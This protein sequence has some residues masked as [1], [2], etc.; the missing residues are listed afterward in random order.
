MKD[1][2][3]TIG[4]SRTAT[5]EEIKK[6]Y[7]QKAKELHPDKEG[8]D[9]E[10]MKALVTAYQVLSD[11]DRRAKYDNTG[12]I[13]EDNEEA[14]ITE[15][16]IQV[17]M[18][19]LSQVPADELPY[20][21]MVKKSKGKVYEAITNTRKEIKRAHEEIKTLTDVR[22]RLTRRN[23]QDNILSGTVQSAIDTLTGAIKQAEEHLRILDLVHK[24]FDDYHF[25]V[26]QNRPAAQVPN[27]QMFSVGHG[28]HLSKELQDMIE[29][30]MGKKP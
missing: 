18:L 23:S 1:L 11:P 2:Y 9:E 8:G 26:D 12:E 22:N 29:N 10:K 4:V 25:R 24:G 6:A 28:I 16:M 7:K 13:D 17:F 3:E 20:T 30:I 19:Q 14:Q 27:V 5:P 15:M 21:D